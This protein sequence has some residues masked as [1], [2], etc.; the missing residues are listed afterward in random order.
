LLKKPASVNSTFGF[1]TFIPPCCRLRE[2]AGLTESHNLDLTFSVLFNLANQYANNEM[3]TEALNTY[4]VL[5][6]SWAQ[7]YDFRIYS[8]NA[9]DLVD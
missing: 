1:T 7:S 4:Q 6:N 2:Q 9:R 3:Y 5:R 8:Y